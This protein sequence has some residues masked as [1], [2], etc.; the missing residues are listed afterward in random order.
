MRQGHRARD[1]IAT[2]GCWSNLKV[3]PATLNTGTP[4]QLAQQSPML[5][6]MLAINSVNCRVSSTGLIARC[7]ARARTVHHCGLAAIEAIP[8]DSGSTLRYIALAFSSLPIMLS[9]ECSPGSFL[10][11]FS[12]SA[13]AP[14]ID[15]R[16]VERPRPAGLAA[17]V[18]GLA[19]CNLWRLASIRG[20]VEARSCAVIKF[21]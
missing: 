19:A 9:H 1:G 6:L 7:D 17:A 8:K 14:Q 15:R 18:L 13:I 12:A 5:S 4:R 10:L 16:R 11:L 3:P 20:A 21:R 2:R